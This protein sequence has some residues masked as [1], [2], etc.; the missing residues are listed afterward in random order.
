MHRILA[1]W[2]LGGLVLSARPPHRYTL[3]HVEATAFSLKGITN[4]GTVSNV[5]TVAADPAFLPLGTEIRVYRAGRFDATYI[6][7]DTGA[8]VLGRHIDI[9]MR[10]PIVARDFGKRMVWIHVI[11][12]GNGSVSPH[13]D[14]V[15]HRRAV[16]KLAVNARAA[17]AARSACAEKPC[18][19]AR[20]PVRGT[21][22]YTTGHS[23]P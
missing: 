7:A 13:A 15:V 5:G 21:S 4:A 2:I 12:W 6:V 18:S 19:K 14:R 16:R 1:L 3:Y 11:R 9:Y 10:S 22:P 8:K 17:A 23:S 20:V